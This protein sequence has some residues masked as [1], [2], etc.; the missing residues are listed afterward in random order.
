MSMAYP[1]ATE[2]LFGRLPRRD[3]LAVCAYLNRKPSP[4]RV[5]CHWEDSAAFLG[6]L[7]AAARMQ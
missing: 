6:R 1:A 2:R 5:D 7:A 3:I 4:S